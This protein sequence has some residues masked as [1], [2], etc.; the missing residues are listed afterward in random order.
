MFKFL[1]ALLSVLLMLTS[2]TSA[3]H[4]AKR[5]GPPEDM[6]EDVEIMA[7]AD[8][9]AKAQYSYY[10]YYHYSYRYYYPAYYRYVYRYYRYYY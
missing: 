3:I 10:R 9:D 1:L 2:T 4:I 6:P 5:S 7:D 8:A